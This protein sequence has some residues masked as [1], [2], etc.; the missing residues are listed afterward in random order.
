MINPDKIFE[1]FKNKKEELKNACKIFRDITTSLIIWI[2]GIMLAVFVVN[3]IIE[4][5]FRW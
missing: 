3:R 1:P 2:L 5:I 4:M